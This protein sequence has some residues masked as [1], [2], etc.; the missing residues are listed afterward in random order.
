[1]T[2]AR[3]SDNE[4]IVNESELSDIPWIDYMKEYFKITEVDGKNVK[5]ICQQCLPKKVILSTSKISPAN[6]IKHIEVIKC[7]DL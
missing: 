4:K 7:C 6:L 1:M 2:N 5:V 3:E